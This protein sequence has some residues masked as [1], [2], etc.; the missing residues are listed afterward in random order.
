VLA[1][2]VVAAV[3]LGCRG[4]VCSGAKDFIV[5]AAATVAQAA[6]ASFSARLRGGRFWRRR[7]PPQLAVNHGWPC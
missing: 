3:C 5:A 4:A 1:G 2:D 6:A 7:P